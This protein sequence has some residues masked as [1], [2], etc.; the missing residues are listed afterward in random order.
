MRLRNLHIRNFRGIQCASFDLETNSHRIVG[1]N[2]SGKSSFIDAIHFLLS[3]TVSDLQGHEV[4]RTSFGEYA[5]HIRE[6]P[7][8]AYVS[9]TFD[10][11]EQTV[12]LRRDVTDRSNPYLPN[13]DNRRIPGALKR[14]IDEA[15]QDYHHL[16]RD[17]LLEFILSTDRQREEKIEELLGISTISQYRA[18]LNGANKKMG[19]RVES[20]RT[21]HRS[22]RTEFIDT[23]ED[24]TTERE[25]IKIINNIRT[26]FG[27]EPLDEIEAESFTEGLES[28][29]LPETYPLQLPSIEKRLSDVQEWFDIDVV[30]LLAADEEMR[31]LVRE[32]ESTEVTE[33]LENLE[34]LELGRSV[35]DPDEHARC[36]LCHT[37]QDIDELHYDIQERITDLEQVKEKRARLDE[38]RKQAQTLL[39]DA[40]SAISTLIDELETSN[41]STKRLRSLRKRVG[42]WKT[43]LIEGNRTTLPQPD[44][45]SSERREYLVPQEAKERLEEIQYLV[46][47]LPPLSRIEDRIG[48]LESAAD[49]YESLQ[50]AQSKRNRIDNAR[51][52]LEELRER[53]LQARETALNQEFSEISKR[54]IE[55]YSQLHNDGEVVDFSA[56]LTP[57]E[58]GVNLSASFADE[59]HHDPVALHSEG[60]QDSMGLCLFLSMLDTLA[61]DA[62]DIVLLD[63]V[64]MSIDAAHRSEIAD[65]LREGFVGKYQVIVTTHDSI[66]DRHLGRTGTINAKLAFNECDVHGGLQSDN[67]P[68]YPW[69]RIDT[70][71]QEGDKTS[72]AAWIRKT[73]EWYT[74]EA[75]SQW[76]LEVPYHKLYKN[77][78]TLGD[79]LQPVLNQYEEFLDQPSVNDSTRLDQAELADRMDEFQQ[80]SSIPDEALPILNNNV[81][82]QAR[83]PADYTRQEIERDRDRFKQLQD[84]LCCPDC[85]KIIK[86]TSSNEYAA[87]AVTC[88]CN[89]GVWWYYDT[90]SADLVTIRQDYS[91]S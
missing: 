42:R 3:G 17:E 91:L 61:D 83:L 86:S 33:S 38:L 81:H 84:H 82:Y 40:E 85:Y 69:E 77:E 22:K 24:V 26:D 72:A 10:D 21:T 52:Q 49:R 48:R 70:L 34:L 30:D 75:C 19:D 16:S 32:L 6:D 71:I 88:E 63:D 79:I 62:V 8:D 80:L 2:G 20:A 87:Q 78:I 5:S 60:H 23:F 76:R 90:E 54:F 45:T 55:L 59:G 39:A 47:S 41:K 57:T 7:E 29:G 43:E 44:S 35:L 31:E 13:Q 11:G 36:P 89:S 67:P 56:K 1:P 68:T 46:D 66:W 64:V 53:F 74:T 14:Q 51:K 9:G 4:G 27:A 15:K 65:L 12:T 73:A 25:A 58:H 37:P 28:P 50:D 18:A